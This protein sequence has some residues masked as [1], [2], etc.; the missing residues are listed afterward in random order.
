MPRNLGATGSGGDGQIRRMNRLLISLLAIVLGGCS[1]PS[2]DG[3]IRWDGK[4]WRFPGG[5]VATAGSMAA[6]GG[7]VL[8]VDP[9]GGATVGE[10]GVWLDALKGSGIQN[11]TLMDLK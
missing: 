2:P 11:V 9:E 5:E 4:S 7:G 3:A 6:R 1:K 8:V 10:C